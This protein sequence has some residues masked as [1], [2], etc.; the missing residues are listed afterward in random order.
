M[1][2]GHDAGK[3]R[4][5]GRIGSVIK[6]KWKVEARIG[7]GGMAT[8]Y[9]AKHRNGNRV[10]I[11]MLHPDFSR[12]DSLRTRFLREGYV[13]NAVGHPGA[14][15]VL[16]DDVTEDGIVFLVME[17]LEG[18]SLE[19][20]RQRMGGRI[21]VEEVFTVGDQLLDLLAAAHAKGI[22]HRDIKPENIFVT[23][24]GLV[25]VLDFGIARMRDGS[26]HTGTGLMLGTPDFMSPEQAG[27]HPSEV[28]ARSDLWA[29]G[30]TLFTLLSGQVV[31]KAETLR[32]HLMAAATIPARS[33][34]VVTQ[35]VPP[36]VTAV[37]D[38]ALELHKERRWPDA[39]AMQDALRWAYRSVS[40]GDEVH[41]MTIMAEPAVA[42]T[43]MFG[44]PSIEDASPS[45][46]EKTV[47]R[48]PPTEAMTDHH[49]P[50][51][52]HSSARLSRPSSSGLSRPSSS[53]GFLL[54]DNPML[55]IP[56][57]SRPSSAMTARSSSPVDETV[58][59]RQKDSGGGG[60]GSGRLLMGLLIALVTVLAAIGTFVAAGGLQGRTPPR[61]PAPPSAFVPPSAVAPTA[62]SHATGASTVEPV[63]PQPGMPLGFRANDPPSI[64]VTAL[65]LAPVQRRRPPPVQ[66]AAS[67]DTT[68]EAPGA[69]S[70]AA[71]APSNS[72]GSLAPNSTAT[73]SPTTTA[74]SPWGY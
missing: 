47:M 5:A 62:T 52:P 36:Q 68:L 55:P 48:P 19:A 64:P 58:R 1:A 39:H 60:S 7:A 66:A 10:A 44:P 12:D 11:K 8:V 46:D 50:P 57:A 18:E 51:P 71:V 73:P 33:L 72:A 54:G 74:S 63:A 41:S 9:A 40:Q 2:E 38:R 34:A 43:S 17:L 24:E 37:V 70:S 4:S 15:R 31:H 42:P 67:A 69:A 25:K 56:Q 49:R 23:H 21:P 3:R 27:G 61:E 22:I 35:G 20:R 59:G 29:A 16:D 26:E 30:A 28:D 13:A 53:G 32:D 14:V 45:S 65:P 6:D